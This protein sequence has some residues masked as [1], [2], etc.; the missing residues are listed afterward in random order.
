[1]ARTIVPVIPAN[2]NGFDNTPFDVDGAQ[3]I[4]FPILRVLKDPDVKVAISPD[5]VTTVT[6]IWKRKRKNK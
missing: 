6:M 4:G 3:K 5:C 2:K 1:M